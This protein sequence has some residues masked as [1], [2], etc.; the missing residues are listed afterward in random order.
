VDAASAPG[1]VKIF[2]SGL[3]VVATGVA[4]SGVA[5]QADV[6]GASVGA[7]GVIGADSAAEAPKTGASTCA[8]GGSK[9]VGIDGAVS[10]IVG[11]GVGTE[12]TSGATGPT[13]RGSIAVGS[14]VSFA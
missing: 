9:E 3:A 6:A 8:A 4:M 11:L 5:G 2:A 7:T 13:A 14:G 1:K 10:G 12:G